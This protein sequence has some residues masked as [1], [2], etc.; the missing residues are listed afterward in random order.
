MTQPAKKVEHLALRHPI[1]AETNFVGVALP[2]KPPID[3][4]VAATLVMY[5]NSKPL[6]L[7]E[8]WNDNKVAPEQHALWRDAHIY[9]IDLGDRKYHQAGVKSSAEFVATHLGMLDTLT[10]GFQKLLDMVNRNNATGYLR[11]MKF[12][13]AYIIREAYELKDDEAFHVELVS[14]A[15]NIAESYALVENGNVIQSVENLEEVFPD[16]VDKLRKSMDSPLTLGRYLRDLWALGEGANDI[17][18]KIGFWLDQFAAVEKRAAE[19]EITLS[20][21]KPKPWSVAGRAGIVIRSDDHFLLKAATRN[22]QWGIRIVV[23]GPGHTTISANG[24]DLTRVAEVLQRLE[25]DRWYFQ[26]QMGAIINGGPQYTGVLPTELSV[27]HLIQML[28]AKVQP[29][30][31]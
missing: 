18:A 17:R 23:T 14:K 28:Q 2:R 16:L 31:K 10:P 30:A 3:K 11:G 1:N 13:I 7:I 19:A 25:P 12:S 27:T 5:R 4:V 24:L 8:F 9:T 21:L 26:A 6:E 29:E 20:N 15:M 22:R